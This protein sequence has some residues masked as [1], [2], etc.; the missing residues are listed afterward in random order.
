L[1]DLQRRNIVQNSPSI[2]N[3]FRQAITSV[4]DPE[5]MKM[6]GPLLGMKGAITE[7]ALQEI[8]TA[9]GWGY[10][11]AY[12]ALYGP[13]P[14]VESSW[15]FI[16]ASFGKVLDA[17]CEGKLFTGIDGQPVQT[18]DL[19]VEDIPHSRIL[20]C[21]NLALMDYR[22]KGSGHT[23]FSPIIPPSGQELYDWWLG[24]NKRTADVGFDF[25]AD[26]HVFPRYVIAIDLVVFS[27]GEAERCDTL[28]RLLAEDAM[29]MGCSEYKTHVAYMDL[30]ADHFDHNGS[31]LRKYVSALEDTMDPK[32]ILSP[33]KQGIWGSRYC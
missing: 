33:R 1:S 11:Q 22:G 14:I 19:P 12:F 21:N 3:L 13:K 16:K 20:H 30:I 31:A 6:L 18:A 28:Y 23:C 26:F 32:G 17:K 10:W 24:A 4:M 9:R 7:A 8:A 27:A 25:F 29:K 5:V 2:A 15:H